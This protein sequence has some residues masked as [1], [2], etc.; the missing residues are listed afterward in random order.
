MVLIFR[1]SGNGF[2]WLTID[3]ASRLANMYGVQSA[4]LLEL[5]RLASA[6]DASSWSRLGVRRTI[7][8]LENLVGMY[9][10]QPLQKDLAITDWTK[11][12]LSYL[13]KLCKLYHPF[14]GTDLKTPQTTAM[15]HGKFTNF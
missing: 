8:S 6:L 3:D 15:Q 11:P 13:Q 12:T 14:H 4:G 10:K 1:V 7:I 5:G 2:L 9:L